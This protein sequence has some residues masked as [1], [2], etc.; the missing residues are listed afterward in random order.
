AGWIALAVG[1]TVWPRLRPD[2]HT[3]PPAQPPAENTGGAPVTMTTRVSVSSRSSTNAAASSVSIGSLSELRRSGRFRVTVA[4]APSRVK[5]TLSP[6]RAERITGAAPSHLAVWR[7]G[8]VS[9]RAGSGENAERGRRLE[10]GKD[11]RPG[12]AEMAGGGLGE[13]MAEVGRHREVAPL[14]ELVAVEAGPAAVDAAAADAAAKDEHRRRV[15]V[16]GAAITVLGDGAPELRHREH[17]DVRHL[18]AEILR[19]CR[20]RR[21]EVPE[22]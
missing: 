12:H 11:R 8:L 20:E 13:E 5:V 4:I 9:R 22:A 6:M 21:A 15:A 2:T 7:G 18:V 17:H 16:V 3:L 1:G 14:E 19:E 10:A